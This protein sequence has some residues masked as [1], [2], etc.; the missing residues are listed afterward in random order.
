MPVISGDTGKGS[1][2]ERLLGLLFPRRCPV[3]DDI[4]LPEDVDICPGCMDKLVLIQEPVCK[5]CGKEILSEHEEL[6]EGCKKRPFSFEQGVVLYHYNDAA[7]ASIVRVKYKGRRSYLHFYARQAALHAGA[8]IRQMQVDA[9]VPIPVHASRRRK[10]GYNQA[11]VLAELLGDALELPVYPDALARRKPTAA[12]K[13][14]GAGERLK[15]LSQAFYAGELP[16]G[17][18]AVC[19]VDDIFTTGATM[20]ACT[21]ILRQAGV[22]RVYCFSLC[23]RSNS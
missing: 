14:M 20:E 10:R 13:E 3:C 2:P 4:V 21:R 17:I 23:T 6:C 1:W 15:S 7:A 11:E 5:Q 16:E 18:E 8:R 12:L 22:T 9:L 19:L